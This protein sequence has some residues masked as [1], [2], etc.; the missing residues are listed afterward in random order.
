MSREG[1]TVE[2]WKEAWATFL[3][4]F[5][6]FLIFFFYYGYLLC[7]ALSDTITEWKNELCFKKLHFSRDTANTR[8]T[9][10]I[11]LLRILPSAVQEIDAVAVK[12]KIGSLRLTRIAWD[13]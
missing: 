8:E 4:F 11:K 1:I 3:F 6:F 12:T 13:S 2:R 10:K 9:Q 5:F 7:Q